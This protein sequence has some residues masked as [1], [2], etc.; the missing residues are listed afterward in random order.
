VSPTKKEKRDPQKEEAM[1]TKTVVNGAG[2]TKKS[3][4]IPRP[5]KSSKI[6]RG[7]RTKEQGNK[8]NCSG[9][10]GSKHS[11]RM[12]EG[13]NHA[14][15]KKEEARTRTTN[16]KTRCNWDIRIR[17][18][19]KQETIGEGTEEDTKLEDGRGKRKTP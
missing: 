1:K 2:T 15:Q 5:Q 11:K 16:K 18:R 4:T 19:K 12:G 6:G 10:R 8:I 9:K 17:K 13:Y 14:E 3:Q 7:G